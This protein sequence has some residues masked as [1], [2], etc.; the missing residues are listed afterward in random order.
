M[1]LKLAILARVSTEA[2][3][4]KGESIRTQVKQLK[5]SAKNCGFEIVKQYVGQEHAT[6]DSNRLIFDKLMSDVDKGYFDAVM[7][8]DLSRWSR[9]SHVTKNTFAKL[10]E[11]RVR[12]FILGE[13]KDLFNSEHMFELGMLAEV[14]QYVAAQNARKSIDNKIELAKRGWPSNGR[15]PFGRKLLQDSDKSGQAKW[16]LNEE[17]Y[18]QAQLIYKYYVEDNMGLEKIAP[19]VG[20]HSSTVRKVLTQHWNCNWLLTFKEKGKLRDKVEIKLPAIYTDKQINR[21]K[22]TLSTRQK[23]R[24]SKNI[25]PLAHY[26]RCSNCGRALYGQSNS[27]H[28]RYQHGNR[29]NENCIKSVKASDIESAVFSHLGMLLKNSTHLKKS[30]ERIFEKNDSKLN[31]NQ[32]ALNKYISKLNECNTQIS[33]IVLAIQKG[34]V[35]HQLAQKNLSVL[36][37]TKTN[38]EYTIDKL[39]AEI[40]D[41]Q[42]LDTELIDEKVE[43]VVNSLVSLNGHAPSIWNELFGEEGL[44]MQAKL[45]RCLFGTNNK[46]L[47]VFVKV[48]SGSG[49]NRVIEYEIRGIIGIGG[50]LISKEALEYD[51]EFSE[52]TDDSIL[53]MRELD[54]IVNQLS[55]KFTPSM[56][57]KYTGNNIKVPMRSWSPHRR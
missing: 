36:E 40:D 53:N 57:K 20:M 24:P 31:R 30:V 37:E 7:V 3:G 52:L 1:V 39:E 27:D 17:E 14:H 41:F 43:T 48:H 33:N 23:F 29:L 21:I 22:D 34:V 55:S 5:K 8:C 46:F 38:L 49:A 26:I 6:P 50:G 9:D 51:Q 45:A 4:K 2:Q 25:Y 42:L 12:F 47:G 28:R 35:S 32:D 54:S 13:E 11:N 10:R 56:P 44:K 16:V 19:L 18:Q 15:L